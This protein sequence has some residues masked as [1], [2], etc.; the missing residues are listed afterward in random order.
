MKVSVLASGSKGNCTFVETNGIRILIDLGVSRNY[1]ENKLKEIDVNP[2]SID[3]V[4]ITHTHNDHISG[5]ASFY[6]KYKPT[7]CI[8][9]GM[10]EVLKKI[11][12]DFS[13][14]L[15]DEIL[16]NNVNI[17]L[18]NTSH[19]IGDSVGFIIE[20][21]LVY[22]TDTGYLNQKY[23]GMLKNKEIYILE[24][25]HDIEMLIDGNYPHNLKQ[26]I[27]GEKGHLSNKDAARYLSKLI[28]KKTKYI[29]L[30]HLSGENNTGEK[31]IETLL[32]YI[33]EDKV[34]KIIVTNQ[35]DRT[36]LITI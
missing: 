21:K 4:L 36:E 16:I 22:V 28:G 29:F 1:I 32:T 5:L 20:D 10:K 12:G 7:I 27:L 2:K 3:I 23:F 31:A 17:K 13:Y 30:A 34:E 8:T 11:I 33:D 24:S 6:N 18:V 14:K 26:R 9:I 25:N 15:Y 35:Y 19:D